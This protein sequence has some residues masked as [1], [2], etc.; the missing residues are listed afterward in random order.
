MLRWWI[1]CWKPSI[2]AGNLVET[3]VT[4]W[5]LF[6]EEPTA[7]ITVDYWHILTQTLHSNGTEDACSIFDA[8]IGKF[9]VAVVCHEAWEKL[10]TPW[11]YK[12]IWRQ[13]T[14]SGFPG[15]VFSWHHPKRLKPNRI[16]VGNFLHLHGGLRIE[17]SAVQR[18]NAPLKRSLNAYCLKSAPEKRS[19]FCGVL[20]QAEHIKQS[21]TISEFFHDTNHHH[22]HTP[23]ASIAHRTHR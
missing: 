16:A 19:R 23:N 20:Q 11:R 6:W 1:H 7:W 21:S 10:Q 9:D 3:L 14:G 8:G 2:W 17:F 13:M 4:C 12:A 5:M 22:H 15:H 18:F